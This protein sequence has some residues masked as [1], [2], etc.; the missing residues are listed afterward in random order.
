MARP[1]SIPVVANRNEAILKIIIEEPCEQEPES[2]TPRRD[3]WVP[4]PN[5]ESEE[6][7]RYYTQE[8][9]REL[10]VTKSTE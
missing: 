6:P 9:F 10:T 1:A 5:L 2:E 4:C 3:S 8:E 7:D